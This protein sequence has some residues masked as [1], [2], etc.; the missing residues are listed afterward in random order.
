MTES[1]KNTEQGAQTGKEKQGQAFGC[2]TEM[3]KKMAGDEKMKK[4]FHDCC[5]KMAGFMEC[6]KTQKE[7]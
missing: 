3:F 4:I 2:C 5:G 1:E 7:K 6:A